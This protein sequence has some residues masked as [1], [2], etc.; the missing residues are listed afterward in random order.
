M[1]SINIEF[2]AEY[3]ERIEHFFPTTKSIR[4]LKSILG[5]EQERAF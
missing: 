4:L 3:P 2:D 5:H 1:R